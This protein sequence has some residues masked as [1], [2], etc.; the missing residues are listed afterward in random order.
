[1]TKY[2]S[3]GTAQFGLEYGITNKSG[4]IKP[5]EIARILNLASQSSIRFIDTAYSYGESEYLIGRS[6]PKDHNFKF[7][8]K[9]P[10]LNNFEMGQNYIDNLEKK[11]EI[12]LFNLKQKFLD[13]LLIHRVQDLKGPKGK[14]LIKWLNSLQDRN[15]VKKIGISI[16]EKDDLIDIP[17][18]EFQIIQLPL[19]LYDQRLLKNG[20]IDY[21]I[22]K[23][24]T[25]HCRSIFLQG[26][27]LEDI[28]NWPKYLSE[29]F[30][31][32]H[33]KNHLHF[34]NKNLKPL[35]VA[36]QFIKMQENIE[37]TIVGVSS[38]E[39]L[40]EIKN[41]WNNIENKELKINFN[42]FAWS[43]ASDLDPRKWTL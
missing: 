1:M 15:L 34:K 33:L 31:Q 39:D 8:S 2:L 23:N 40:L 16:Y 24:I 32:T 14:K 28:K 43:N 22:S 25:V 10:P 6:L 9:I 5:L 13:I 37:S 27:I 3:L 4:Q 42:D 11:L 30:R 17:L 21:L 26:L 35:E 41:C 36:L 19:S 29:D 20:T 38:Y 12:S 18:D 7:S